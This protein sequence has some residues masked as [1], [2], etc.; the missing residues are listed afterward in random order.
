MI[1]TPSV[2]KRDGE[3]GVSAAGGGDAGFILAQLPRSTDNSF[4]ALSF[5]LLPAFYFRSSRSAAKNRAKT[6][7]ITPFMVKKAALSWERSFA[8]TKKCS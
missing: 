2:T 6:T 3:T 8:L 7:E 4:G 1:F 5:S